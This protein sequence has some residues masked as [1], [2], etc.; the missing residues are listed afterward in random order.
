MVYNW[1]PGVP[2]DDDL[3]MD[4]PTVTDDTFDYAVQ[5]LSLPV[6]YIN[7]PMQTSMGGRYRVVS[8]GYTELRPEVDAITAH[9]ASIQLVD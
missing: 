9:V 5:H 6:N 8:L 7:C 1:V 2:T 4:G 3:Y